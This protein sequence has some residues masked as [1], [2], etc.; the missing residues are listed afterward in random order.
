MT[1]G[2]NEFILNMLQKENVT[3]ITGTAGLNRNV[4]FNGLPAKQE[5]QLLLGDVKMTT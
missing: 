5:A 1:D 2:F 3:A 4:Y